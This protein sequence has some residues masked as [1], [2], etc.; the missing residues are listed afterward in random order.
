MQSPYKKA[1]LPLFGVLSATGFVIFLFFY[2]PNYVT[3]S[4]AIVYDYI[5]FYLNEI[6]DFIFPVISASLIFTLYKGHSPKKAILPALLLGASKFLH[7]FIYQYLYHTAWGND[8]SE[9]IFNSLL[10]NLAIVL[11]NALFIYILSALSALA[12]SL[13][14]KRGNVP[15]GGM[16]ELASP[17]TAG[18][19]A[20]SLACFA[21]SIVQEIIAIISGLIEHGFDFKTSEII[22][23]TANLLIPFILLF[24]AHALSFLAAK[25]TQK[26]KEDIS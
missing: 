14:K 24:A 23:T 16:L 17:Q 26:K 3:S 9:S 5:Y 10:D 4:Q 22:M 21:V 12:Y 15:E 7:L 6:Y 11:I 20:A 1:L 18:I 13:M 25:R 8:W 2:I 19:F